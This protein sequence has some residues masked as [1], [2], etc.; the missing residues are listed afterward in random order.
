MK[1]TPR[2]YQAI[3]WDSV[4]LHLQV[5]APGFAHMQITARISSLILISLTCNCP[6]GTCWKWLSK[7]S[8]KNNVISLNTDPK[9]R[10]ESFSVQEPPRPSMQRSSPQA[11]GPSRSPKPRSV[12]CTAALH[13][14]EATKTE[15]G[16][17]NCLSTSS[18]GPA[19]CTS[20]NT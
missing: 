5:T 17:A 6:A 19:S 7:T 2:D 18:V 4:G 20:E 13:T 16:Y 10:C 3:L 9:M 8:L 11:A 12:R 15:H 14:A 1:E